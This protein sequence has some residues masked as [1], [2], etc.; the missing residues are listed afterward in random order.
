MEQQIE[1]TAIW[2]HRAFLEGLQVLVD[3]VDVEKAIMKH[4]VIVFRGNK[5]PLWPR[6]E[7]VFRLI[8]HRNKI[9]IDIIH[10]SIDL[11]IFIIRTK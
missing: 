9:F 11:Y 4:V 1:S 3:G 10:Y 8:T 2:R 6:A 5:T 7:G